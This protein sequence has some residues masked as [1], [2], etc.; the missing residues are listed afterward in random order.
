M[1]QWSQQIGVVCSCD[2]C[3]FLPI[4]I[5]NHRLV[6][7]EV[8]CIWRHVNRVAHPV[9]NQKKRLSESRRYFFS[10]WLC[11]FSE[12]RKSFLFL[13]LLVSIDNSHSISWHRPCKSSTCAMRLCCK[14]VGFCCEG[15][16]RLWLLVSIQREASRVVVR[17]ANTCMETRLNYG[18]CW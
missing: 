1:F 13:V 14:V 17:P 18:W 3:Y 12:E 5:G 6:Y 15:C 11:F 9:F 10:F 4:S 7:W 8:F 2:R 16:D